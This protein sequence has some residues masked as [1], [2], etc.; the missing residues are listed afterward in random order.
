MKID[1]LNTQ[2]AVVLGALI[3]VEGLIF[4]AAESSLG[5]VISGVLFFASFNGNRARLPGHQ[6]PDASQPQVFASEDL[7]GRPCP[8][9][10]RPSD[11]LAAGSRAPYAL[12]LVAKVDLMRRG[13]KGLTAALNVQ[14]V[15]G[16]GIGPEELSNYQLSSAVVFND[17]RIGRHLSRTTG[18]LGRIGC[19]PANA[20][21]MDT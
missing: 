2:T 3:A 9:I 5:R 17:Q 10:R 14:F 15:P 7:T 11:G 19:P 21:R 12:R 8:A 1:R 20:T 13:M 6:F 18:R 4:Q 16:G